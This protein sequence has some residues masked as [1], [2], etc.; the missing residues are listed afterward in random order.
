MKK[1]LTALALFG[2]FAT[3][4]FAQ[5]ACNCDG[6]DSVVSLGDNPVAL[7]SHKIAARRHGLNSFAMVPG[8]P[9]IQFKRPCGHGWRQPRL[10]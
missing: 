10:Q 3:P 7:Q 2:V 9:G 1:L 5:S 8:T 4:A 6:A